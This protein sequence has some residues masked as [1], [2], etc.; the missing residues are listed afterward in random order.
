MPC[1]CQAAC[2]CNVT[3]GAGISVQRLGDNFVISSTTGPQTTFIQEADP[4]PLP[5]PYIWWELDG[6]GNL[7]TTW[8]FTP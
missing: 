1:G 2:G 7:V 6:L 3:A 5:Y 4:G 8:V